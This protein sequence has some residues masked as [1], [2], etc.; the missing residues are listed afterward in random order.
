[1]IGGIPGGWEGSFWEL[2]SRSK[3]Q[4]GVRS[5]SFMARTLF[6]QEEPKWMETFPS[7]LSQLQS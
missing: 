6:W 1:M 2:P 5:S 4:S 7:P 3:R